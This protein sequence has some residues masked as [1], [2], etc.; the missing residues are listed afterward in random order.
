MP[1]TIVFACLL[2]KVKG[3]K[4][5]PLFK[6]WTIYPVLIFEIFFLFEQAIFYFGNYNYIEFTKSLNPIYICTYLILVFKYNLYKET[7]IGTSCMIFGGILNDIVIKANNGFMPVYPSL[8]YITGYVT[9]QTFSIV[10]DI[11][12]LGDSESKLKFLTDFIDIGYSILSI[13]DIFIR[14]FVFIIIFYSIKNINS[15]RSKEN[16]EVN[17]I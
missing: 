12:M 6:S 7:L 3:Y 1:E 4:I 11:H 15:K 13:G 14:G 8:S 10:N 2:A 9:P 16:V 17:I 5:K